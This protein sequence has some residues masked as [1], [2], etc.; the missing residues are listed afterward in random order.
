MK[1]VFTILR[2]H[3]IFQAEIAMHV[4]LETLK[5]VKIFQVIDNNFAINL[6]N[7]INML[8]TMLKNGYRQQQKINI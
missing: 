6:I 8:K 5:K 4:H 1:S 2:S 3:H 7:L